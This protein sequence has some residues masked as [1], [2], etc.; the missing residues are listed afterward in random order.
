LSCL[1]DIGYYNISA[2]LMSTGESAISCTTF[3]T[4]SGNALGIPA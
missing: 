4:K 3:Y 2:S 1:T